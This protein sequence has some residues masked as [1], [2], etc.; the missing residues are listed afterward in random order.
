MNMTEQP[1]PAV[2]DQMVDCTRGH[3]LWT[4][5]P[6]E[7]GVVRAECQAGECD[8][9]VSLC[10]DRAVSGYDCIRCAGEVWDVVDATPD[11][12]VLECESCG[13]TVELWLRDPD[14]SGAA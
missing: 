9:V 5:V 6:A 7:E 8:D 3:Q 2:P 4:I 14:G 12:R 10:V 11:H 1:T 13:H